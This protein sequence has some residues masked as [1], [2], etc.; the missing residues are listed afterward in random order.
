MNAQNIKETY[1]KHYQAFQKH[2]VY[3][4]LTE[5]E[6]QKIAKA[7]KNATT[8]R[9][10]YS[11]YG[12]A[13]KQEVQNAFMLGFCGEVAVGKLLGHTL[14]EMELTAKGRLGNYAHPDL[15]C[16]GLNC[17]VKVSRYENPPL[18]VDHPFPDSSQM[19]SPEVICTARAEDIQ[20]DAT[21]SIVRIEGIWVNGV[22]S[23]DVLKVYSSPSL[24]YQAEKPK[25]A[26]RCGF[27]GFDKL[28]PLDS[29]KAIS[30][31]LQCYSL[32]CPT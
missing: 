14:E 5:A 6:C 8:L 28:M 13:N 22:A 31:F 2:Y 15:K 18:L 20:K 19:Q 1:L 24:V 30:H 17:G 3:V 10:G 11:G 9:F 27:Y 21:N 12:G 26:N 29:Q 32:K 23:I 7:A 25:Y 4:P 16:I